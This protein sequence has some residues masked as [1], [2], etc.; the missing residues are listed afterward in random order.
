MDKPNLI[1]R[2]TFIAGER[3]ADDYCVYFEC[4]SVGRIQR[5]TKNVG[6]KPEWDWFINPPLPI[7]SG[8]SGS[9]S[10]LEEAKA[11]IRRAW[12]RFYSSLTPDTIAHWH[13]TADARK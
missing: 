5:E 11:A 6:Q 3:I 4:R 10:D 13:R 9:E 8:C 2:P 1:L 12:E 7:P